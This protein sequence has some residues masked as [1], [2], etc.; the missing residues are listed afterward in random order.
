MKLSQIILEEY[1][2]ESTKYQEI[3][4]NSGSCDDTIKTLTRLTQAYKD[5]LYIEG[6]IE[7]A[8][9]YSMPREVLLD[10][11]TISELD[12]SIRLRNILKMAKINTLGEVYKVKKVEYLRF[13]NAGRRTLKELEAVFVDLGFNDWK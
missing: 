2:E 9:S 5:A 1:Q 7:K 4:K 11:M 10:G 12:V 3:Y 6:E 8:K 13:K